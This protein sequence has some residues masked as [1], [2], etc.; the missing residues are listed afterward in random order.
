MRL[1]FLSW[2]GTSERHYELLH[3]IDIHV[4]YYGFMYVP[5]NTRTLKLLLYEVYHQ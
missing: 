4:Y 2:T 5:Q 3:H 1:E